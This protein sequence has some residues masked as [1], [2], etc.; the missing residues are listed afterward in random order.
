MH[1]VYTNADLLKKNNILNLYIHSAC[2]VY[3][4]C[5]LCITNE[6]FFLSIFVCFE[7][8]FLN[9]VLN[10]IY[11]TGKFILYSLMFNRLRL[12]HGIIW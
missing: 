11:K 7:N 2:D 3:A 4:L 8:N 6:S 1:Y 10:E 5:C 12:I 9:E